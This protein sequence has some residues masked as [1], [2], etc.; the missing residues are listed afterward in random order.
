MMVILSLSRNVKLCVLTHIYSRRCDIF[1]VSK[2][3]VWP[4]SGL[5]VNVMENYGKLFC[6]Y[7]TNE[8][9]ATDIRERNSYGMQ[10]IIDLEDMTTILFQ[11]RVI[12]N[13]KINMPK[14]T[15]ILEIC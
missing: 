3:N 1:N 5:S 15:H 4:V 13:S 12:S 14:S 2:I 8:K 7:S 6:V 10:T 11:F 9:N